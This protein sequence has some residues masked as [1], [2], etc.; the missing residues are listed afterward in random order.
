MKMLNFFKFATK[1]ALMTALATV[2]ITLTGCSVGNAPRPRLG[3]YATSTPGTN[4]IDLDTLGD[5]LYHYTPFNNE[6]SGIT[7]TCRGGHID[8][9]HLRICADYTRYLYNESKSHLQKSDEE[10]TFKL[11]VE[12]S[13]YYANFE[14]PEN[15]NLLSQQEKELIIDE[16]SLELGMYFT[17]TMNIWHEI[18]TWFGF[19]CMGIVPEHPSAFSWEDIYSN[20]LGIRLGAAAATHKE[21]DYDK[22]MGILLKEKL[23][24]LEILPS[25]EA[26]YAAEKMRG[27]WFDGTFFVDMRRRNMDVGFYDGFIKPILSPDMCEDAEP[28][29][30]PA[31]SLDKFYEYGFDLHLKIEPRVFEQVPILEIIYPEGGSRIVDAQKHLPIIMEH[32]IAQGIERGYKVMPDDLKAGK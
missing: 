25:K 11:N 22:A 15:W 9:A 13:I 28:Y 26:K 1:L 17:H 4:F 7:Y 5:H 18:L 10:F 23:E 3:S 16:V 14:Y 31:P 21:L 29:Y 30:L 6:V 12:P 32:I 24:F 19:K 2:N 8:I 20:A 27:D